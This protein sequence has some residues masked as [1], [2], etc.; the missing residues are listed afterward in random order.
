MNA[1]SDHSAIADMGF[2]ADVRRQPL[3]YRDCERQSCDYAGLPCH[4]H[5][6]GVGRLR[7]GGHRGDVAGA[8]EILIEG[9]MHGLVDGEW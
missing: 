9:A 8:A 1:G 4:H 5:G 6:M 2:N 3:K 7:D